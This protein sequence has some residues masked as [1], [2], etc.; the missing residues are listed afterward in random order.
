M[1][2]MQQADAALKAQLKATLRELTALDGVAGQETA[3][4]RWLRDRLTP[5]ADEV[6]VDRMGNVLATKRGAGGGS[7]LLIEAHSDEIGGLVTAIEADGKIRFAKNGGVVETLLVAR[8]VRV[9][10]VPGI[11]GVKSGHLQSA[12][13]R[14]RVP[15]VRDL[16]IDVGYDTL[17]EVAALGISVGTPITYDAPLSELANGDRVYGKAVDNRISCAILVHLLERL[18]GE[19]LGGTLTC[20]IAVQEEVGLRGAEVVAYQAEPDYILV[21]DTMPSGDAPDLSLTRDLNARIGAGPV[22]RLMGGSGASGHHMPPQMARMLMD[23]AARAGIPVQPVVLEGSANDAGTMHRVRG[24]IPAAAINL[25]RR[26]SHSPVELLDL[27]DAAHALLL[28]EAVARD[29]GTHT[30]EF[31]RD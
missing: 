7:H 19:T 22:L 28:A 20:A 18:R 3:V 9:G 24:G 4:V 14:L 16:Y 11:V 25:A 23:T 21:L 12:D 17:E 15:S 31:L 29:L 1:V 10:S 27:N 13:E 8:K 26:Y 6:R 30:L 2:A 5:L